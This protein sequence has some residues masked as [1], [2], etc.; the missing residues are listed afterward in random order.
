MT[1]RL[2]TGIAAVAL[3]A[4][5]AATGYGRPGTNPA[6]NGTWNANDEWYVVMRFTFDNG[7]FWWELR[8]GDESP[9]TMRGT[10]TNSSDAINLSPTH[11]HRNVFDLTTG[12]E[13]LDHRAVLDMAGG[14][15]ELAA[16]FDYPWVIPF[17]LTGDRLSLTIWGETAD[18]ARR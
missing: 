10:F 14:A 8:V 6:L 5:I 9:L 16:I 3:M 1:K 15:G 7:N 18:F 11:L 12:P 2:T 13:W 17:L 4:G